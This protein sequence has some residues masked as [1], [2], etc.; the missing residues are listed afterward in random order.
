VAGGTTT[1]ASQFGAE[2]ARRAE[3]DVIGKQL[4]VFRV[5]PT[6]DDDVVRLQLEAGHVHEA[7]LDAA[8]QQG[9]EPDGGKGEHPANY[10]PIGTQ[11]QPQEQSVEITTILKLSFRHCMLTAYRRIPNGRRSIGKVQMR[12]APLAAEA[13][14]RCAGTRG[15]DST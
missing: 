12:V 13:C 15:A 10:R 2:L 6:L 14:G 7:V 3:F 8:S 9:G 4:L 11:V 5:R 1:L